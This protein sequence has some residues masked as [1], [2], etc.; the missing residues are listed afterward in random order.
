MTDKSEGLTQ[1]GMV[2][3]NQSTEALISCILGYQVNVRS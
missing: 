2:T 3:L 1:A